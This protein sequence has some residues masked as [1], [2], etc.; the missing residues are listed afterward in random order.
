MFNI[1]IPHH[2]ERNPIFENHAGQSNIQPIYSN[3]I[4]LR[5]LTTIQIVSTWGFFSET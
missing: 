2:Q 3:K 4:T 1:P 5:R